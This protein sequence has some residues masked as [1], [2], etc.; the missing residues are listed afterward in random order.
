VP[1]GITAEE[2]A[3]E[4]G[5]TCVPAT[6][7]SVWGKA[8]RGAPR[9]SRSR[10]KERLGQSKLILLMQSYA[11]GSNCRVSPSSRVSP[12]SQTCK[13]ELRGGWAAR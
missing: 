7:K 9:W 5:R 8:E 10:S 4:A 12:G 13:R 11:V 6:M 1:I 2:H 3:G